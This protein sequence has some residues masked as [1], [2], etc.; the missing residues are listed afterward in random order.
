MVG[1]ASHRWQDKCISK[2]GKKARHKRSLPAPAVLRTPEKTKRKCWTDC[3]MKAAMEAVGKGQSLNQASWDH[4]VPKTT[5]WDRIHGRIQHSTKPGP[6]PYLEP[7]EEIDLVS[8]IE[9]CASIGYGKSRKYIMCIAQSAAESKELLRKNVITNGW[10]RRFMVRHNK[11]LLR[12]GD[13][14]AYIRMDAINEETLAEY[15]DLLEDS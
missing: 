3:Q 11:L 7:S 9:R 5:L 12:K 10:W 2:R 1:V 15:F 6:K 13:S 8:F 4:G 14:T